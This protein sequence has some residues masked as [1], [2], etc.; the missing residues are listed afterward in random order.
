[1]PDSSLF[2]RLKSGTEQ[3]HREIEAAADPLHTFSSREAYKAHLLRSWM[4]HAALEDELGALDWRPV[5]IDFASRRKTPLLEQDLHF[6]GV[7][8]PPAERTHLALTQR[9]LNFAVGCLYVLEGATLG[10]QVISRHLATLGI[11]PSNGG[12]FFNGYGARTGEMWTSFKVKATE[13]CVTEDQIGT[14]VDG[15][16]WTFAAFMSSMA[17]RAVISDGP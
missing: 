13:H 1:M 5:G 2:T 8:R 9:N 10:G 6:L 14:A 17:R 3:A 11:G 15:A 16:V 12:L 4:F 7:S